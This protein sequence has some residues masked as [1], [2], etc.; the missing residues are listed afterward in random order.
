[1]SGRKK[2]GEGTDGGGKGWRRK[3][4]GKRWK[5]VRWDS[6]SRPSEGKGGQAL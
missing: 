2:V 4:G 6:K 5:R 3:M 1:M